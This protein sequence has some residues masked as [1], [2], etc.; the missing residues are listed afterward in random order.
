MIKHAEF[1]LEN[2]GISKFLYYQAA[3]K[4]EIDAGQVE[5]VR[6]SPIPG[7][8]PCRAIVEGENCYLR[9]DLISDTT[10]EMRNSN[11]A[12]RQSLYN[13][14]LNIAETLVDA[15][16]SGLE[17]ENFVFG[18]RDIFID[19]FSNRLVFIYLP[20]KV[21]IFEKVSL[22][23]FLRELL[24]SARYDENEDALFFVRLHN[25]LVSMEAVTPENLME[26]LNAL[27]GDTDA[28]YTMP[29]K[30]SEPFFQKA[31][32]ENPTGSLPN[33]TA[34]QK[35]DGEALAAPM[36]VSNE[37]N[38]APHTT[39]ANEDVSVPHLTAAHLDSDGEENTVM[40]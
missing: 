11:P 15:K 10:L 36:S 29:T 13:S 19:N 18:Q 26:K 30:A 37:K 2:H 1:T 38:P 14:F 17:I 35:S 33:Q 34:D 23:D 8:L 24:L 16:E 28:F 25:Y 12:T 3:S 5:Y 20:V 9:Y 32:G 4:E 39:S 22:K 6:N 21:N 40:Q 7:I 27:A 31:A